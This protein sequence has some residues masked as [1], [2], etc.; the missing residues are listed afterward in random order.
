MLLTDRN[1][2]TAFFDP[3]GG[4]DPVLF[5]ALFWLFGHPEVYI[6]VLPAFGIIR[7]SIKAIRG[8]KEVFGHLGMIYAMAAIGVLGCAV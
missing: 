6:L 5:E 1:L 3:R 2:N 8:K 4:G 7:H